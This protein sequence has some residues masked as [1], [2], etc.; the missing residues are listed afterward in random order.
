MTLAWGIH[1]VSMWWN[2]HSSAPPA[3]PPTAPLHPPRAPPA[4]QLPHAFAAARATRGAEQLLSAQLLSLGDALPPPPLPPEPSPPPPPLPLPPEPSPPLLLSY[5]DGEASAIE[6]DGPPL[7]LHMIV[8]TF[9]ALGMLVLACS[10]RAQ[11][12][13]LV[14]RRQ[15]RDHPIVEARPVLQVYG[16][17]P[18]HDTS[19][20]VPLTAAT[21]DDVEE[22]HDA[23]ELD[24]LPPHADEL[25]P[26]AH[27]P[28]ASD[29]PAM[30]SGAV[31]S[32]GTAEESV[33]AVP[34]RE[35]SPQRTL[36]FTELRVG[37]PVAVGERVGVPV[38]MPAADGA[39]GRGEAPT[40]DAIG[41]SLSRG[42]VVAAAA[43]AA[44]ADPRFAL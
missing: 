2:A 3:S 35:W 24:E 22:A 19:H 1:L 4:E 33:V 36:A 28:P 30:T 18:T 9:S 40:P 41:A 31:P 37:A 29:E 6:I 12:V 39:D 34:A 20:D 13:R 32:S 38:D 10:L 21:D 25:P 17:V 23:H 8:S 43:A 16:V 11:T 7:I 42:A 5:L 44:L 27:E 15:F 26:H 14:P